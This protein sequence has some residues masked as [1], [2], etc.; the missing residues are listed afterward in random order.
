MAER[1]AKASATAR[2]NGRVGRP[3]RLS[4]S[5]ILA[6]AGRLAEAGGAS[7]VTMRGVA[8]QLGVSTMALYRHVA[9]KDALLLAVLDGR[10]EARRAPRLPKDARGRILRNL[11]WIHDGI[12]AEPWAVEVIAHGEVP[13]PALQPRV[14]QVLDDFAAAGL[15][16]RQ[17]AEAYQTCWR[18][19][20]GALL[21]RYTATDAAAAL[22]G[23]R[24]EF[25][26]ARGL[27]AIVDGLL[28]RN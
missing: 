21:L 6:V 25:D 12:D 2:S 23:G 13:A 19:T 11:R 5:D 22:P 15:T 1:A 3:A 26:Y 8:A 28:V 14:E 10:L 4:R 17:A 16:G 27:A 7:N 18:Y 24:R 9:D 20:V